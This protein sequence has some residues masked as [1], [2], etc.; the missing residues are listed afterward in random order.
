MMKIGLT[1]SIGMGKSTCGQMLQDLGVPVHD[2]D[3]VVHALLAE[4]GKAEAEVIKQFPSLIAPIDRKALGQIVFND[5]QS[6]QELEAILHPLV[7]ADRDA[8]F[9]RHADKDMAAADIPLLY[10]T[11]CEAELDVVIV[12]SAS[13]ETQRARVLARP[14]MTEDKLT[15]ILARQMPDTNKRARADYVVDTG[16]CLLYTSP[17][18]RD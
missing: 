6:R 8:F 9:Q 4:G 17:S 10:E 12:V 13:I 1:G 16:T 18:P 11:G 7:R 14:G 5:D 2:S 3:K 15:A